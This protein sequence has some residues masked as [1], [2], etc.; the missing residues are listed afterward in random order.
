MSRVPE[1]KKSSSN[2]TFKSTIEQY[3]IKNFKSKKT[4]VGSIKIKDIINSKV[5]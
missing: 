4:I 1:I 2:K 3:K 5:S